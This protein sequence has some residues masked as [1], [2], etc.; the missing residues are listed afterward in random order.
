MAKVQHP[1]NPAYAGRRCGLTFADGKALTEEGL[2]ETQRYHF[3][4]WGFTVTGDTVEKT[5]ASKKGKTG[6]PT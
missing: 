2:S 1:T 3:K 6:E 4:R 5:E